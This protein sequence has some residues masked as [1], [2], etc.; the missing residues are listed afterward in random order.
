MMYFKLSI[1]VT[2]MKYF[3]CLVDM[4]FVILQRCPTCSFS[5]FYSHLYLAKLLTT[6]Y[7]Q[8]CKLN[9]FS[10]SIHVF[11]ADN[12][13]CRILLSFCER[14]Q[15]ILI[16]AVPCLSS[17]FLRACFLSSLYVLQA[18]STHDRSALC[19]FNAQTDSIQVLELRSSQQLL[20]AE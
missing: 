7:I 17:T 2:L 10:D 18:K 4:H 3:Q 15:T 5:K 16:A 19:N 13:K 14:C 6:A 9:M 1:I 11:Q 8:H 12:K 20:L